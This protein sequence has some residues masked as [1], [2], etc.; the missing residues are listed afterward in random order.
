MVSLRLFD[1]CDRERLARPVRLKARRKEEGILGIIILED[2]EPSAK[3]NLATMIVRALTVVESDR[4]S[5]LSKIISFPTLMG[6]LN[7]NFTTNKV[8]LHGIR[9]CNI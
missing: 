4:M 9:C 8:N 7:C 1:I 2:V 3:C 6:Y 5:F